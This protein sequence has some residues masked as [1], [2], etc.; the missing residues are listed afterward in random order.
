MSD[1]RR[2]QGAGAEKPP[3]WRENERIKAEMGLPDYEP[4]RFEDGT[5]THAVVEALE[6]RYDCEVRFVGLN[7]GYPDDWHVR[8]DDV[9]EFTVGYR[10]D[11]NG[12]TVFQV[13]AEEFEDRVREIVEPG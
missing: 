1:R 2:G 6:R 10:R 3:W 9:D 13:P 4:S 8:I 11:R 7:P 5:Y 12:N